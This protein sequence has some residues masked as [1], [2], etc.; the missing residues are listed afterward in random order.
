MLSLQKDVQMIVSGD[1]RS[2]QDK[3][4]YRPLSALALA[5]RYEGLADVEI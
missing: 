5:G 3:R 1:Q 4:Y 2:F